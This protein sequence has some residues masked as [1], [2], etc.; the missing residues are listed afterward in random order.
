MANKN[1]V[2]LSETH[3]N[4]KLLPK[5]HG[6]TVF[7]DST[8][9]HLT[10]HGGISVYV[11]NDLVPY[12]N[13]LRF[14]KSTLSFRIS[15]I[16]YTFFMGVY[17]Y[18]YDSNNFC[19][20]DY[21]ELIR[22]IMYW[23]DKG[24]QP[25]IGGDF[26]SRIG[27]I[28]QISA[29]SLKWNFM[30]N[31]DEKL[32]NH[33]KL[34]SNMCEILKIL[35]LNHST[36]YKTN[37]DGDYTYYKANNKSQIDFVLTNNTGR[38]NVV[39]YSIIKTGWHFSDHLPLDLTI[40]MS[41]HINPLTLLVRS[42]ELL[43][44]T[45]LQMHS[46][47]IKLC[48]L[49]VINVENA[50]RL[51][52]QD[53]YSITQEI[54]VEHS[55]DKILET[56]Y[57]CKDVPIIPIHDMNSCDE[58]F[59]NYLDL[60]KIQPNNLDEIKQA[61]EIYQS[62]RNDL[63]VHYV[64]RAYNQY[65][66]VLQSND[67]KKLWKMISWS[68]KLDNTTPAVHPPFEEIIEHFESLYEPLKGECDI[69]TLK[70][71]VYIPV[72]DDP[73]TLQEVSSTVRLMKKGGYD[74][75]LTVLHMLLSSIAMVFL[76]LLNAILYKGFPSLIRT[77]ILSVIPKSGNLR[78]S[79]NYRGIQVQPLIA[80][81]YDKIIS[82]RLL[83]WVKINDEQTAFQ[84]GKSTIDQIFMLRLIIALA[85]YQK[86]TLYVGFFDL[87]KAFDRV[88]RYLL[89]KSLVKMGIGSVILEAL[90]CMYYSTRCVLKGFGKLSK[91]FNTYTGIKQG[92]SSSVILFIAFMDD[93]IDILKEKCVQE[94]LLNDLHCLL[95]ADDT[96]T[97]STSRELF[98]TKCNILIAAFEKKKMSLNFKKSGYFIIN[99]KCKDIKCHIRLSNGW[100]SYRQKHKYLGAIFSDTGSIHQ[101]VSTYLSDKS[102]HVNVKLAAFM[103]SNKFAPI[104]V[105]LKVVKTCINAILTY[106]CEAWGSCSLN[107]VEMLQRKALKI[108]M[109]VQKNVPN[110][111]VYV[112]T[113][114]VCLK[115]QIYKRQ[116]KFFRKVKEDAINNP[117]STTSRLFLL[118]MEKNVL[119]LRHYRDLDRKFN[120]EKIC[121]EFYLKEHRNAVTS[122]II[123]K[124]IQDP[125]GCYGPYIKLNPSLSSPEFY[126]DIKCMETDRLLLTRYRTGSHRL[127]INTGRVSQQQRHERLCS[128]L[129]NIQTLEHV[130]LYC[131]LT[132]NIRN[133]YHINTQDLKDIF[134]NQRITYIVS[135]IRSVE[136]I[137]TI[138]SEH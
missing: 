5:V 122:K 54:N 97:L 47:K 81:V 49:K 52:S 82:N 98:I 2:F 4:V 128:C 94:P 31:V 113:D 136:R 26:N 80:I 76:F 8:H 35:P 53:A 89:L 33:G 63:H 92:A 57:K 72:T 123:S 117:L 105:K 18:P 120:S 110:E 14:S 135:M 16:P 103:F 56:I 42:K 111:I 78:L 9:P 66:N 15:T 115:A 118:G 37:F 102:K 134:E 60:I 65:K 114:F 12:V 62:K 130:I 40:K 101:D 25:Y 108:A 11:K 74:Y 51:L 64:E 87:S 107:V 119:Y 116:L 125:D 48:N 132:E 104:P 96:L 84:K 133:I 126:R 83:Q 121:Y 36:Y 69:T 67:G 50:K 13:D 112:E 100:L 88:S 71:D 131:P 10:K 46:D 99:G 7:G 45:P 43:H 6:F 90:K 127:K 41:W 68:G 55:T 21:A 38:V 39:D 32:N 93:I 23:M 86:M 129:E 61:Y 58:S 1:L 138:N 59:N 17:I 3:A 75:P 137:L 106:S 85:K 79:E 29:K 77:S 95:H 22:D 44:H 27:D 124:G 30:G 28:N 24:Y 20:T 73:I 70:S 91:V 34:F 109:S 19:D